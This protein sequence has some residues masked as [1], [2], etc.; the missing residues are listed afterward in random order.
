MSR[1]FCLRALARAYVTWLREQDERRAAAE[2]VAA[3]KHAL[4][5]VDLLG[6]RYAPYH[7]AAGG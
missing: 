5:T 6:D 2:L 7:L 3:D 4:S 1:I